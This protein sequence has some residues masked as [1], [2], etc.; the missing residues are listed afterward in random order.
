MVSKTWGLGVKK[1]HPRLGGRPDLGLPRLPCVNAA[2]RG[3]FEP[4]LCNAWVCEAVDIQQRLESR[5]AWRFEG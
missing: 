3:L 4:T 1:A 5:T 2:L